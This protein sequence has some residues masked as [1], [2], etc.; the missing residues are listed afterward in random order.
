MS[1]ADTIYLTQ[2]NILKK[3][4][5]GNCTIEDIIENFIE[6]KY[7]Y[8]FED[9]IMV[10]DNRENLLKIVNNVVELCNKPIDKNSINNMENYLESIKFEEKKNVMNIINEIT[11]QIETNKFYELIKNI[12]FFASKIKYSKLNSINPNE[13]LFCICEYKKNFFDSN[14]DKLKIYK[15]K[16]N[17][18]A[19]LQFAN[20]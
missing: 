4:D 13:Y 7:N 18:Y 10:I 19:Q 14:K 16:I 6:K 9:I 5:Y 15:I 1:L 11:K 20:L 17:G 12:K 3:Y 8:I 2:I